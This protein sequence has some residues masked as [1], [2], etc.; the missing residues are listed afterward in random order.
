MAEVDDGAR[1]TV[2]IVISA[3]DREDGQVR[4]IFDDVAVASGAATQE[5]R[6]TCLYTWNE[7]DADDLANM[8]LSD[9]DY[10]R[11]GEMVVARIAALR[12]TRR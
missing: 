7:Y 5:W 4:L 12:A 8:N 9:E 10:Q 3:V 1:G 11:I 2:G 6:A